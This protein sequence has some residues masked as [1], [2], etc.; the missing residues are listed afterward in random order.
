MSS[1]KKYFGFFFFIV[2]AGCSPT[3]PDVNPDEGKLERLF[4]LPEVLSETSGIIIYDSLLWTFNDSG[5]E[6]VLFGI[7][8]SDSSLTKEIYLQNAV[9]ID[10]EDITQ[11]EHTIYIGDIG[12]SS[13]NRELLTIYLL[14]KDSITPEHVQHLTVNEIIYSYADQ[15]DFSSRYLTTEYDCEALFSMNDSLYL[16]TKDWLN[17]TTSLYSLPKIPGHYLVKK[18]LNFDSE[19]LVTGATYSANEKQLA[20]CGY[21]NFIPFIIM[22]ELETIA[23]FE[24]LRYSR[25]DLLSNAGLQ[26]EGIDYAEDQIYVTSE[27]SIEIQALYRFSVN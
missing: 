12:N 16:L 24:N 17:N 22:M 10:W 21:Y 1:A 23:D 14:S 2:S 27:N 9:N 15:E 6:P 11:D 7:K 20:I 8:L 25:Y 18:I 13:G 4:T 3:S 5:S 19:G 26:I